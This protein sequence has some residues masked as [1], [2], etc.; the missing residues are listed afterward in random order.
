[1]KDETV[2]EIVDLTGQLAKMLV[3]I[4][5]VTPAD[6]EAMEKMTAAHKQLRSIDIAELAERPERAGFTK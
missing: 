6:W 2:K 5:P 1:M 4:E 3:T